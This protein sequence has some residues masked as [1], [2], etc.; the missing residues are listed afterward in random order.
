MAAIAITA[1]NVLPSSTSISQTTGV[2]AAGVTATQGQYLYTL[3]DGTYGLADANVTDRW[4]VSGVAL[5]G[6]SPGQRI[7]I[8]E[9]GNDAAFVFGG[10]GTVGAVLYLSPT[11]GG[12]TETYADIASA[13]KVVIL[14]QAVTATTM[15][16][17]TLGV[18]VTKP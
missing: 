11:A 6:G 1:A 17:K 3:S 14:G 18:Q 8:L 9:P 7:N 16:F 4:T 15:T 5:S 12:I 2:L 13:E 10:T